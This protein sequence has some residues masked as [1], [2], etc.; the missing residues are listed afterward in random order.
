MGIYYAKNPFQKLH[1]QDGK[2]TNLTQLSSMLKIAKVVML[3]SKHEDAKAH[4]WSPKSNSGVQLLRLLNWSGASAQ[5]LHLQQNKKKK[6]VKIAQTYVWIISSYIRNPGLAPFYL[7][8]QVAEDRRRLW[9]VRLSWQN[10]VICERLGAGPRLRS[11]DQGGFGT[12]SYILTGLWS[13]LPCCL[14][15]LMW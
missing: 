10:R 1:I 15:C 9:N 12:D 13:P 14:C 8:N 3:W 2:K 11:P 6:K 5:H 7:C 4:V